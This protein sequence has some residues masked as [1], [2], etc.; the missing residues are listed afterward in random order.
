M[1]HVAIMRKSWGL[2]PKIL[3]G[4]KTV[5]SRWYVSRRTPWGRIAVGDTVWFKDGGEPV[6]ARA[7]VARVESF[8]DLTPE[9]VVSLLRRHGRAIGLGRREISAFLA[10]L[11]DKRYCVLIHLHDA[12][13]VAPFAIDKRGFGNAAAWLTVG[14]IRRI[15]LADDLE[16]IPGVGPSIAADLRGLGIRRVAD[17]KGRDPERL[18]ADLQRKAGVHV[19]RCVLYVFRCAAYFATAKRHRPELLKWWNWKDQ[20]PVAT[21]NLA[22]RPLNL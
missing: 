18:Y 6:T 5:E 22:A 7:T 3:T 20:G 14:D 16:Q 15:R 2:I 1:H 8:A 11:K 9:R 4:E 17:L 19:D 10:R 21:T 13:P 12:R